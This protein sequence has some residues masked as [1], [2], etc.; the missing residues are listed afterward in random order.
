MFLIPLALSLVQTTFVPL[1]HKPLPPSKDDFYFVA[2]GDNRPAGPGL[3]PTATY[4]ELL[5]EVTV[6][7]P[8]FII[9]TG[10]LL[11]GNDDTMDQYR[12]E[13]TWIKP[14]LEDLPCP[15]YNVPGNHEIDNKPDFMA[16]YTKS[17]GPL[18]GR[19]DF[20]G[21]R[22]LAVCT[23]LPAPKPG[24]YG[25]ELDW[26]TKEMSTSS[27]TFTYQHH[28]V[29][30][31]D[32]NPDSK[33]EAQASNADQLHALYQKGGVK[34]AF[35]GHDHVYN[36]QDHDG[37]KYVI[38]GGSGAPLD[39]VP[40]DGGYF[41]FVLVHVS[42]S[43]IEETPIPM[44]AIE[45]VPQGAGQTTIAN[46]CD[47]DLPVANLKVLCMGRP[48]GVSAGYWAKGGKFKPV[49]ASIVDVK[50]VQGRYVAQ[51]SL[52]LPKHHAIIVKLAP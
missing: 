18:Y 37:V 40:T 41:H 26:L 35:E 51:V 31:R 47:T 50:Q 30:K 1:N 27:P 6:L 21:Y 44:G 8:S 17:L 11:Y 29:F 19:F 32:T 43:N 39:A 7:G 13:I 20:G 52:L 2:L 46:Y 10:D 28:P 48:T 4:K 15:F 36:V 49:D 5:K 25:D 14:L 38:A 16:E 3:P 23:E 33:D 22:F 12:Q 9:S 34:I 45:V 24:V 42:G